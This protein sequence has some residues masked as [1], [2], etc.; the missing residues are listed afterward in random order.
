MTRLPTDPAA[1]LSALIRC[2]S[3]TPAEGGALTAL[4]A[5]LEPMGFSVERPVFRQEGTPDVENMLAVRGTRGPHLAFNGHTD[6]VPPG[7]EGDWRHPPFSAAVED[8]EMF[9]RGAVDMKG[10]IACFVAA[11]ARLVEKGALEEGRVS[12]LITGDEEGVAINGTVKLLAHAAERGHRFDACLV[13]EPT[14]PDALG[15]II[16]IGRR[17]SLSGLVTI[18]GAQGHVAYPHRARNP[19]RVLPAV[20]EALQGVP[21]DEGTADFQPSNLEW[22]SVDTGNRAANVIAARVSAAFNVRFND[23]WTGE[24]LRAEIERRLAASVAQADGFT[25]GVEWKEPVADAFLTA[26][27][28][29]TR[30]LAGAVEE[31]TGRRPELSTSGGTSDARFVKDFCPVV[32]FGL[33]GRTMHMAN[34]RVALSDLESLTRVY[35]TFIARWFA[36]NA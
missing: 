24:T 2:V 22:T 11:L 30:A 19:M 35:E 34:E 32:E 1:N 28:P 4:Q 25:V 20:M 16:K 13:G 12:L 21:L 7:D 6:V 5:M 26:E 23:V 8:G 3:V 17:G 27:G 10:G 31:E 36:A 18:T 15:D 33:V 14:N 29:L 9:G